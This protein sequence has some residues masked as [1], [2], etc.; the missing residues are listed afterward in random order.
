MSDGTEPYL[1]GSRGIAYRWFYG[2]ESLLFAKMKPRCESRGSGANSE[3][4]EWTA[5]M[6]QDESV[7]VVQGAA[8]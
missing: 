7:G 4:M 6:V 1:K 3:A 5:I 8:F 2:S